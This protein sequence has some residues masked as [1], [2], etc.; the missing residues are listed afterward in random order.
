MM[1]HNP[2]RE[3]VLLILVTLI[4]SE[5]DYDDIIALQ[6]YSAGKERK[7]ERDTPQ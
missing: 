3:Y 5:F 4:G 7:R 2:T 6:Q 1:E